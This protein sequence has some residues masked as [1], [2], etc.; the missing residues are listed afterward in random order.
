MLRNGPA[1]KK[2][3]YGTAHRGVLYAPA[4]HT[5]GTERTGCH[6]IARERDIPGVV[7]KNGSD[8]LDRIH[9]DNRGGNVLCRAGQ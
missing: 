5:G 8:L 7:R 6:G 9:V 4:Q 2:D 3:A 1:M